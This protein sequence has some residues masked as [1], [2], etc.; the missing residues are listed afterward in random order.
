MKAKNQKMQKSCHKKL[1]YKD[2][3]NHL[4]ATQF[5]NK[6]IH[7]RKNKTDLKSF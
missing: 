4:E 6:I 5:E 2:Y 3:R 7:P 1:K